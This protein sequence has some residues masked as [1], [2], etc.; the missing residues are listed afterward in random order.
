MIQVLLNECD[1][2]GALELI[3]LAS[4]YLNGGL[5][6][7]DSPTKAPIDEENPEVKELIEGGAVVLHD[8]SSFISKK[9]DMK[10]VKSL[11]SLSLQLVEISKTI[12]SVMESDL[13]D[14]LLKD[15]HK[16]SQTPIGIKS[17]KSKPLSLVSPFLKNAPI[18]LWIEHI[19]NNQFTQLHT[20]N[21]V[22]S[23][24]SA[25]LLAEF[26]DL[27]AKLVPVVLGLLRINRFDEA[28]N[29]YK[30]RL[31]SEIKN[32]TKKVYFLTFILSIILQICTYQKIPTP[33]S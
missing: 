7:R 15:L 9:V 5:Y 17:L 31:M 18:S 3:E 21:V 12:Y 29:S 11:T 33:A 4:K 30:D 25:D 8:I 1:Y 2:V 26:E 10:G 6:A 28:L 22:V 13:I 20:T 19:A 24:P 14:I 23:L 32:L 16:I 27:K